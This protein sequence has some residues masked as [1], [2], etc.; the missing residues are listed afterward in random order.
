MLL[1]R[2][3]LDAG[4]IRRLVINILA[5]QPGMTEQVLDEIIDGSMTGARKHITRMTPQLASLIA[6]VEQWLSGEVG[7]N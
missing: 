3:V 6:E 1:V 2:G 7:H 4:Q 5:R